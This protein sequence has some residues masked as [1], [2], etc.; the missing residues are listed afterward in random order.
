MSFGNKL[1]ECRKDKG[2]SQSELAKLLSTNHSIIG[3][4]ERDEV[5][6]TVDAVRKLANA[7]DTTLGY[8]LGESEDKEMLKDPIM[9]GRL[10][11]IHNLQEADKTYILKALDAM[12]RDAKTRKA[13]GNAS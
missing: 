10:N 11:D 12:I 3:K 2:L 9:M 5:N 8:L 6:P 13:Y 4:Y 1:K 7:L